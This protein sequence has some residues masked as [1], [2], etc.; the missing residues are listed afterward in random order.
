[1][2]IQAHLDPEI[3]EAAKKAA[4]AEGISL[5]E[6]LRKLLNENVGNDDGGSRNGEG[7]EVGDQRAS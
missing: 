6:Y 4:E 5:S 2:N 7:P 1:M 3:L